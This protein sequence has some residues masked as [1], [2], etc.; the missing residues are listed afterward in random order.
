M[1]ATTSCLAAG[2]RLPLQ[3][4]SATIRGSKAAKLS[5]KRA[6]VFI[7]R[8]VKRTRTKVVTV[9]HHKH[10]KRVIVYVPNASASHLPATLSPSLHGLRSGTHALRITLTYTRTRHVKHRT[11]RTTVTKT[12]K[13]TF[14]VC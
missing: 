13:T 14:A 4:G 6:T 11:V 5:F 3:L 8:G 9:H 10:R 2:A 1:P 12:I 7:D